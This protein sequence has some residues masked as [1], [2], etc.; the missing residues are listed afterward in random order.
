MG[1]SPTEVKAKRWKCEQCS[2]ELTYDAASQKLKCGFCGFTRDVP[3]EGGAVV[4]HDLFEGLSAAPRGFG[5][6]TRISRCQECGANVAFTD[7]VT[8]TRCTFCGSARVLEQSENQN[9]LRPESLLAFAVDKKAANQRFAAWLKK[10]WFRPNDLKRLAKVQEVNGV[11]VPFWTFDSDVDSR[12][13]A[14]AGY[15]YY[16]EEEYTIQQEGRTVEKARRVRHTR[17]ERAWGHRNDH[18]EDLLVC[19]SKGLPA[20]LA[21][22][23]RTFDTQKL[24]PYSPAFLAGWRAEEYAID[25]QGGFS[26]A[27]ETMA[28]SQKQR[29]GKDVPGDTQ[30]NLRVNNRFSHATFKHVLLPVWIAAY[31][32][33]QKVYRFLV[34]GQTGEVVGKA[35]WSWIKLSLL[36]LSLVAV[37]VALYLLFGNRPPPT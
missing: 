32:Y 11:Y 10:L 7:K 28:E 27:K 30:R 9:A 19:A 37:A 15:Y 2:A 5:A 25:L 20:E 14:E 36:V 6:E 33:H 26:T 22:S 1:E 35:P 13:T 8:A 12:W 23:L 3:V 17:W 16:V 34:N 29:C 4:E 31:R 18:Y 24:V 21:S